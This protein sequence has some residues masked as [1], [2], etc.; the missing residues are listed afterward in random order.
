MCG[1]VG[2]LNYIGTSQISETKIKIMTDAIINRGPDD[3]GLYCDGPV[4][5]GFR[6]LSILD[7]SDSGHQPFSS[8]DQRYTMVFNG[9]IYNYSEF[10]LEL[11]TKGYKFRSKSD[12]EVLLYLYIE[13]GEKVLD[14]LNGMFAFCIWDK[15]EKKLFI[16]RDRNGV[17]PLYYAILGD[18]I[19][20]GSEPKSLFKVGVSR[21]I[22]DNQI[23]EWLLFRYISGENTI[24]KFV[25]KL[26]PGHFIKVKNGN[27]NITR[28]Y[29]LSEKIL[30]HNPISNPTGW[31][32]DTFNSALNLRMIS[33]VPVGVLLSGGL[34]SS[35]IS[36][37]LS[38]LN[39]EGLKAFNVGFGDFILDESKIA[40]RLSSELG[41]E[42]HSKQFYGEQLRNAIT[43][44][45]VA[46]DEP[47]MH[48]N[49][50]Q[51]YAIANY[52]NKFVKVLISG[53]GAD[54]LLSGYVRYEPLKRPIL[55]KTLGLLLKILP[56]SFKNPRFFK[57]EKYNKLANINE[58]VIFNACNYLPVDFESFLGI[59]DNLDLEYRKK[60]LKEAEMVYPNNP[61][62]QVLYLDQHTYLQSLNDR[63]DRTTMRASIE[64]REPFQDYRLAE[65][66][67]SLSNKSIF[68]NGK[69]KYLLR[70][71][72]I[73]VLP[74]YI[75]NF[76]KIGFV[77]PIRKYIEE[78]NIMN[79][80][81]SGLQNSKIFE[82]PILCRMNKNLLFNSPE[83]YP[84]RQQLWFFHLWYK[85]NQNEE[86]F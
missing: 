68:G 84:I 66:I 25:K 76:K 61:S 3:E 54:E 48:G 71:S 49:E 57:L 58:R 14:K 44:S 40:G 22:N 63:N 17:K 79:E 20:F 32:L 64:C 10:Y 12:T 11:E 8:I 55:G 29:N 69:S 1:F 51:I 33:D 85:H 52:A 50:P 65:G 34:D 70:N 60:I 38:N 6:R 35:S 82:L 78:D 30:N 9:E 43:E 18:E 75:L 21:E 45:T 67:G 36:A 59:S 77:P 62:R 83:F 27:I 2:I 37:S 15:V 16:A 39:Y 26:L 86:I 24:Y 4:G 53:E 19:I 56:N 41:F 28:W 7:L 13:Y 5:L 73:T 74:E 42:F 46:L 80:S 47:I 31:F 72:M 23:L 81:F